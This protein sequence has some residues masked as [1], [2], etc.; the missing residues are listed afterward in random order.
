MSV[1]EV[2]RRGGRNLSG[3]LGSTN[4]EIRDAQ[5]RDEA[6]RQA[7]LAEPRRQLD[8]LLEQ[9][10][11]L[12]LQDVVVVPESCAPAL[13]ELRQQL[14]AQ[15]KVGSRLIDRLHTGARTADV[16]ETIF[17][18]EEIIAP[19]TPTPGARSFDDTDLI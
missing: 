17:T 14:T 8:Q 6:R 3:P 1:A 12:N 13:A 7:R 15:P 4:Q 5:R 11:E 18:I 19:P 10:E 9:L 2:G 16:I